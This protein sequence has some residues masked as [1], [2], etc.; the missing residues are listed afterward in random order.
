MRVPSS[1][2]LALSALA[3][4]AG[5]GHGNKADASTTTH[6]SDFSGAQPSAPGKAPVH[7]PFAIRGTPRAT[8]EASSA[9]AGQK[10][11]P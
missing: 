5:C 3:C 6:A 9:V 4:L 11:G 8:P 10:A 7:K 2:F 1:I